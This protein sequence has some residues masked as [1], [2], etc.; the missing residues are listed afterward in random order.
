MA[1]LI[2]RLALVFALIAL[3]GHQPLEKKNNSIE[4]NF[5]ISWLDSKKKAVSQPI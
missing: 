4:S 1:D 5:A 2:K 3:H